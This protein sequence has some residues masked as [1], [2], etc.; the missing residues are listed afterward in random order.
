MRRVQGSPHMTYGHD[1]RSNI[2]KKYNKYSRIY[3]I[4]NILNCSYLHFKI[5]GNHFGDKICELIL[6]DLKSNS[7]QG[8]MGALLI[9]S[10]LL[11]AANQSIKLRS[12]EIIPILYDLLRSNSTFQVFLNYVITIN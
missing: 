6:R 3:L 2:V 8:R 7:E 4:H 9:A 10:H 12:C 11:N 5:L 1:E